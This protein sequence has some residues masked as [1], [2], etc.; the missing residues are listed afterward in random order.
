V[1]RIIFG[2]TLPL[3]GRYSY[4]GRESLCGISLWVRHVNEKGGIYVPSIGKSLPVELLYHDD[5]SDAERVSLLY[6]T[7]ITEKRV[8]FLIGPYASGLCLEAVRIARRHNKTLWNYGGA[9]DEVVREGAGCVV[10]TITPAS[11]YYEGFLELIREL[12]GDELSIAMVYASD[13]G[14][15]RSVAEGTADIAERMGFRCARFTYESGTD[16]VAPILYDIE[17]FGPDVVASAGRLEDELLLASQMI[18]RGIKAKAVGVVAG[19]VDLFAENLGEGAEG[20]FAPSHW[21]PQ[22]RIS[23]DF[24]PSQDEFVANYKKC[25]GRTPQF[26][27]AQAYNI[28]IIIERSILSAGTI[29]D[30]ELRKAAFALSFKTFY[31]DFRLDPMTGEQV[32][33]RMITVQ[34]RGGVR[35]VVY[36]PELREAQALYPLDLK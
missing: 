29:D 4:Q 9:T 3:T 26:L 14:F 31:G 33:H 16:N 24:G 6:E 25:Y 2:T 27:A 1:E 13:S 19:G 7:L 5:E 20:F 32:A 35:V 8:D 34:W 30:L 36:P 15:S 18:A 11:R 28:G 22:V 17:G 23:P 12:D 21:E 10:G